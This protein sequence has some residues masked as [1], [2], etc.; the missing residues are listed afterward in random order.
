MEKIISVNGLD[1]DLPDRR[2]FENLAFDIPKGA[3]TVV[4]GENGVGKTTLVKHLLRDLKTNSHRHFINFSIKRDE[5]FYM[6]QIRN[7]DDD[8]PLAIKDFVALGF[9]HR[10]LPWNNKKMKATLEQ[11]LMETR[12]S[13]LKNNPLGKASGGEKQRAYL[14]Q[15]LCFDPKLLILDEATANLDISSKHELLQLLKKLMKKHD[16]TVIFITHDNE[17]IEEYADYELHLANQ[18]GKLIKKEAKFHV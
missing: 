4:T 15:A 9:K 6:P 7:I 5:A 8:Y 10:I 1:I 13:G 18:S 17:L 12:L 2:L 3:L 16:I 14:A 11:T